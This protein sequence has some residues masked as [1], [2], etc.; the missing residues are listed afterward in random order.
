L[1]DVGH[2]ELSVRR[3]CELLGLS[4]SSWYYEAAPESAENLR[5]MRL[6]DEEYTAHPFYGSRRLTKWLTQQGED[7]NRKRVQRL[8]Q[9][10]G[11]VAIYPK[12][13]LS[14]AAAGHRIYPYL[15]RNVRIER[16]NQVWSTDITYV[17][18]TTGFMYLAAIIDWYS[19]YVIAWR[20]S[21]T[22]DG[23]FC[24]DMLAEAL[25]SGRP[26]VFNTDQGVQ[27]TSQ[28]WTGRVE[29]AGVAVSMDGRGRCLDNVFVERL[30]RSVKYEDIYLRGYEGVPELRTGL[31]RYFPFYNEERPH[32]SLEYRTPGEIY[33]GQCA[34]ENAPEKR[35]ESGSRPGVVGA[36]AGRR[37]DTE[38]PGRG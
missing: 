29:S 38:A 14:A 32:Q 1:I 7:V 21:N 12:P 3:Q 11:L 6:L 13:K 28:A 2:P 31:G 17:P 16:P 23:S 18:L 36:K 19:R 20:L 22:L 33:R 10:M 4:R 5:L 25:S 26:E 27:F 30:W 8:L 34:Q 9:L 24:L 15:L 35:S 37:A